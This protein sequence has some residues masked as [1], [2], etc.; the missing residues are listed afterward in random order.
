MKKKTDSIQLVFKKKTKRLI[1]LKTKQV[2][3]ELA[4]V[5]GINRSLLCHPFNVM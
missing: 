3:N 4:M 2:V 1:L 5:L